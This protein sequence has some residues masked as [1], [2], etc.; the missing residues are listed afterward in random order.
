MMSNIIELLDNNSIL[1]P[2]IQRDYA[3]GRSSE[4]E[5]VDG[6]LNA[7]FEVL[8][9]E[10][11]AL[12]LNYIYGVPRH[13]GKVV[14][15]DGQQR[16]T[17]LFLIRLFLA[18][19]CNENING[20]EFRSNFNYST[21]ITSKYFCEFISKHS[22][23]LRISANGIK[24][25]INNH[26]VFLKK[27]KNDPTVFSMLA[28]LE[29]INE[30]C[31]E[32]KIS[33][34][35]DFAKAL[36]NLKNVSFDFILL[37]GFKREE[38]LYTAM[39]GRGKQ[40][41]IF[42]KNKSRLFGLLKNCE[43]DIENVINNKWIPIFWEYA[44]TV[45]ERN[46]NGFEYA[47]KVHDKFL[48]NYL[49]YLLI[50][51][52]WENNVVKK[53]DDS[54]TFDQAITW[55]EG[56]SDESI[57]TD[58][59]NL[60]LF[61]INSFEKWSKVDFS[62]YLS[63]ERIHN[64]A[65]PKITNLFS[66]NV[67]LEFVKLFCL[68]D[69]LKGSLI[70]RCMFWAFIVGEYK[71]QNVED[72]SDVLQRHFV[73]MRDLYG[74][75]R[76]SHTPNAIIKTPEEFLV[77]R[78]INAFRAIIE[79]NSVVEN[80][81]VEQK[82]TFHSQNDEKYWILNNYCTR[83]C[84]NNFP[85]VVQ[86]DGYSA[87][88]AQLFA[89][90]LDFLILNVGINSQKALEDIGYSYFVNERNKSN[91]LYLPY[92]VDMLQSLFSMESWKSNQRENVWYDSFI[93]DLTTNELK[94]SSK[95]YTVSDW[96]WY[97]ERYEECFVAGNATTL[98]GFDFER[99]ASGRPK[100]YEMCCVYGLKATVNQITSPYVLSAYS[101]KYQITN[102]NKELVIACE[103]YIKENNFKI[104]EIA[105]EIRVEKNGTVEVVSYDEDLVQKILDFIND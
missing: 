37:E 3:Y 10:K 66:N 83:G 1:I 87:Q 95:Q 43:P 22:E 9:G 5:K 84:S 62:T 34:E 4:E 49:R 51:L 13:D 44:R 73:L 53:D 24:E 104:T 88:Q 31:V 100:F 85:K 70:E 71:N 101:Q 32:F 8:I 42:E 21:R 26:K 46:I 58:C 97:L 60:I 45:C 47:V 105:T 61:A 56:L 15:I 90:N 72:N 40:L 79:G 11:N 19:N 77:A 63:K 82:E 28:V 36:E 35:E 93:E 98:A 54:V 23:V 102:I 20:F 52:Y 48:Y 92:T 7:V 59:C 74:A 18:V 68:K 91:R 12:R 89:K 25:Q 50:M 69:E 55:L 94:A 38:T 6:L 64:A 86:Q 29:K 2:E 103:R 30:K 99:D 81:F 27:W 67:D 14:L 80:G 96:Q 57:K 65:M 17:T 39:N 78:A 76:D 33:S 16:T 41:T 75:S